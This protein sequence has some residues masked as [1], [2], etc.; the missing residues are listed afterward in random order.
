RDDLP[1]RVVRRAVDP[2]H[3]SLAEQ[4]EQ[5]VV[6]GLVH[7]PHRTPS[8]PARFSRGV[9][10]ATPRKKQKT[11]E[12]AVFCPRRRPDVRRGAL[13]SVPERRDRRTSASGVIRNRRNVR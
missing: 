13:S 1:A 12:R 7:S 11:S 4:L 6:G 9:T 5:L 3:P 2:P 10:V 8:P